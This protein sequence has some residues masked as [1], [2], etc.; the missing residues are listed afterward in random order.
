[1]YGCDKRL[2]VALCTFF[3]LVLMTET[4]VIGTV[5]AK[6]ISASMLYMLLTQFTNARRPVVPLPPIPNFTGCLPQETVHYGWA[7]WLPNLI[8]EFTLFS[9]ALFKSVQVYRNRRYRGETPNILL[10]LIRDSVF[11]F[12]GVMTVIITNLV[13]WASARVSRMF[14]PQWMPF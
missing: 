9:L 4:I 12:G 14:V 6:M 1:M 7:Y 5:T 3:A 11:Y 2:L 10:V 8:L 13:T